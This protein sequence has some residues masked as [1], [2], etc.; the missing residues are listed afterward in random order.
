MRA[1]NGRPYGVDCT[2]DE[3]VGASIGRPPLA[4]EAIRL[5]I[6]PIHL[7]RLLGYENAEETAKLSLPV[8]ATVLSALSI[9]GN[10]KRCIGSCVKA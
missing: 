3:N 1:T 6:L 10:R 9:P 2:S 7:L 5:G 4:V 8:S